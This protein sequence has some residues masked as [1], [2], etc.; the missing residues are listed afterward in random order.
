[1]AISTSIL[2]Q[3]QMI[4][5]LEDNAMVADIKKALKMI[6]GVASVKMVKTNDDRGI[7]PAMRK[8]MRTAREEYSK[9]ETIT[10]ASP[11]EM[12]RYFDSL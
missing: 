12:Q 5:T 7:T 10:C 8:I 1:M 2:H 6:R 3:P 4:V 11:E 9:G